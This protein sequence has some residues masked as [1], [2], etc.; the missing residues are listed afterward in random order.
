MNV[1]VD[2]PISVPGIGKIIEQRN[3]KFIKRGFDFKIMVVGASG[4]GKTTF[5][6]TLFSYHLKDVDHQKPVLEKGKTVEIKEHSFE[7]KMRLT[8]VDTPGFGDRVNND[9]C[10][11]PIV[12]YIK[13][14]YEDY[15]ITESSVDRPFHFADK[16]VHLVLYFIAPTG[17][18]LKPIDIIAMKNISEHANVVPIIAKS[19]HLTSEER[20]SFK[21]RIKKE[22]AFNEIKLYPFD[23]PNENSVEE[24]ALNSKI[25]SFIPFAVVGS[26]RFVLGNGNNKAGHGRKTRFG[27]IN[28]EDETHC[29]FVPLKSFIMETH[30]QDLIDTTSKLH[31]ENYRRH[32]LSSEDVK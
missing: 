19:D 25:R 20:E 3:N 31:Y 14:Q 24:L 15:L 32:V 27:I 8:I 2:T 21:Q 10:W 5:M 4:L 6:N 30:L 12:N 9:Q 11:E 18:S 28:I 17:H 13:K 23:F 1:Q 22:M 26:E 16:R 29:E 7:I